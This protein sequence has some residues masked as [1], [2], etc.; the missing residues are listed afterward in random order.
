MLLKLS[1]RRHH[2]SN[3]AL[4]AEAQI[5]LVV[6]C[7]D[8]TRTTCHVGTCHTRRD[9]R[10]APCFWQAR[11]CQNAWATQH[12]MFWCNEF[13]FIHKA[14]IKLWP[15][16][17]WKKSTSAGFM[18]VAWN[19]L[20]TFPVRTLYISWL[21]LD[22]CKSLNNKVVPALLY[23][24]QILCQL[25]YLKWVTWLK[26]PYLKNWMNEWMN[27]SINQGK[28]VEHLIQDDWGT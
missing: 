17:F 16:P 3:L 24:Q 12:V 5:P 8:M 18:Q 21:L 4:M 1:H 13:G 11:Q 26:L 7:H 27:E 6:S 14:K 10:V 23:Y 15:V 9:E 19:T 28:F 22:I 25:Y 2:S 20:P